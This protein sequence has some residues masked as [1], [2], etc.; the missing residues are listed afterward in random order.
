M[1]ECVSEGVISVMVPYSSNLWASE[2]IVWFYGVMAH[3]IVRASI[4][5]KIKP[6]KGHEDIYLL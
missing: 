4:S 1:P 6:R 2:V 3:K 5:A